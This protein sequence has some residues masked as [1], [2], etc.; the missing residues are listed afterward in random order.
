ML[1]VPMQ[2][3]GKGQFIV[4]EADES[5]ASFLYLT[6]VVAVVTNIDAD[7]MDTY[8]HDINKLKQAF[9]DFTMRLPFYG[10]AV[11]CVEND[12]VRSILPKI[13]K[14]VITYGFGEDAPDS[15][16]QYPCRRHPDEIYGG[17]F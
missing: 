6:P 11:V 16:H 13:S 1:P 12:N 4:A 17:N 14:P 8:G 5:D 3:L 7:H 2:K 9:V 15:R 10:K